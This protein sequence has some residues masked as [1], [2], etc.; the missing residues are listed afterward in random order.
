[1]GIQRHSMVFYGIL[2]YSTVPDLSLIYPFCHS[3]IHFV[4]HF[5]QDSIPFILGNKEPNGT[6]MGDSICIQWYSIGIQWY[7]MGF[8]GARFVTHLSILSLI[9]RKI[10]YHT[11]PII[12]DNKEPNGTV[13][14][15][16]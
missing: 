12:L 2:W 11:R 9:S 5:S 4:T 14:D 1:M 15:P 10:A 13:M 16:K 6:V 3:F 8:N 7:S